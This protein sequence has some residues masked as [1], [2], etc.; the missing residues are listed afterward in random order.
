LQ[1]YPS[2][3]LAPPELS[4]RILTMR[5]LAQARLADC[6]SQK[7]A[8]PQPAAATPPT[9]PA[10]RKGLPN[11]LAGL[12]S[13]F[14]LRPS[15][16]PANQPAAPAPAT[17]PLQTLQ[18][19]WLEMPV[20]ITALQLQQDPE[21]AQAQIQLAYDTEVVTQQVCGPPAGDNAL[22][23]KIAQDPNQVEEE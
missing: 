21:L 22:L 19:R 2:P 23:L 20:R 8:A 15:G 5:R 11:P 16:Q 12:A 3:R 18:K 9:S 7:P 13:R 4:A 1:L 14:S 10:P 6:V 17:D